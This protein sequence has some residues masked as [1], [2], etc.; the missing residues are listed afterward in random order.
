MHSLATVIYKHPAGSDVRCS[1]NAGE[2]PA[3][4]DWCQPEGGQQA[5]LPT[6]LC[7]AAVLRHSLMAK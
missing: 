3:D 5:D 6:T 2:V 7:V 1:K 4:P